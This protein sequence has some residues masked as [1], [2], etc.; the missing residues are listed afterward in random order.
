MLSF[1]QRKPNVRRRNFLSSAS[2]CI[3]AVTLHRGWSLQ[4]KYNSLQTFAKKF[5]I[6]CLIWLA[7]LSYNLVNAY[8]QEQWV[9]TAIHIAT[10]ISDGNLSLDEVVRAARLKGIKAIIITDRDFMKWEYGLW[11]L[12]NI[13]KVTRESNSVFKYGISNYLE[14]IELASKNNKDI[15]IIPGLESAPFY[16]WKGIPFSGS[17]EICDWH[18]HILVVGLQKPQD[19]LSLPVLANTAGLK[20]PFCA[21]DILKFWPLLLL[22]FGV[23]LFFRRDCSYLDSR[24]QELC[25]FSKKW[26]LTGSVFIVAAIAFLVNNSFAPSLIYDQYCLRS[27]VKPYQTLIDYVNKKGG[28]TFWA[29][30]EAKNISKRGDVTIETDEHVKDLRKT[31]DYTGFAVFF[32]G[33]E[34]IGKPGGEWDHLLREFCEGRRNVPVWAIAGLAFDHGTLQDLMRLMEEVQTYVLAPEFSSEALLTAMRSGR[35]YVSS[36]ATKNRFIL[37]EFLAIDDVSGVAA[38]MG[39]SIEVSGEPVIAIK[40]SRVN[41]GSIEIRLIRDGKIIETFNTTEPVDI[42]YKDNGAPSGKTY[43][44]LEIQ[45]NDQLIVTNPIF[46]KIRS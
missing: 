37:D 18:K 38:A 21:K 34:K 43:Y 30:P 25:N 42:V 32:E 28:M 1:L 5:L 20:H 44:R 46:V 22:F 2:A 36:G 7:L 8:A 23:F 12:R 26:R 17:F 10:T 19:Y 13:L 6:V 16:Y 45:T 41:D 40:G 9:P 31:T 14:Q 15:L 27:G 33:Y 4:Q 11:P 24:G 29:H 39:G 35:M 3:L